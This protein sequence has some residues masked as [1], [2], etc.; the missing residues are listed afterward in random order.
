M[1][2]PL[3]ETDSVEIPPTGDYRIDPNRSTVSFTTRHMFGLAPVRGTFPIREGHIHVGD[4]VR[5][6]VVRA[7]IGAAGVYTGNTIRD[8]MVGSAQYL[9]TERHPDIA[10]VSTGLEETGGRWIL[11]GSLTVRGCT[12]PLDV[13]IESAHTDGSELRLRASCDIDRY[14][15]GITAIKGMTGRRLALR[16]EITADREA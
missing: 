1:A 15:F 11:R 6:S 3:T 14:E 13:R 9:D 7:T 10:F 4:P 12:R 16:L 5:D 2:E 8:A